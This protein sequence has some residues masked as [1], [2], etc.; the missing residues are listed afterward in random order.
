M[1]GLDEN[2]QLLLHCDGIDGSQDFIDSS[3]YNHTINEYNTAQI[4]TANKKW[5]TGSGL[6][7]GDSDYLNFLDHA[8]FDWFG[9]LT[10]YYVIDFWIYFE[11]Y[12][13]N[14]YTFWHHFANSTNY[15]RILFTT[16]LDAIT[17][18]VRKDGE[19]V[20]SMN[21]VGVGMVAD[22]WYHVAFIK[23]DDDWGIYLDGQQIAYKKQTYTFDANSTVIMCKDASD[24]YY[25]HG[26]FDEF[27]IQKSNY[28]NVTVYN[29]GS[30]PGEAW[31]D[32]SGGNGGSITVPTEAYGVGVSSPYT[33]RWNRWT[34]RL[35]KIRTGSTGWTLD[36]F[37]FKWRR[38]Q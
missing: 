35:E 16:S 21:N 10:G 11:S 25:L 9:S 1:P 31:M 36:Y 27:R 15:A 5:G 34:R 17:F 28:F 30:H 4:D 18:F 33:K 38:I 14:T 26:A 22:T 2:T 32:S 3:D 20:W 24:R 29:G 12:G 13:A 8:G 6:F 37:R 7:D 23:I 19:S